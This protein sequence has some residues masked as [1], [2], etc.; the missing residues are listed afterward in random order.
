MLVGEAI[1]AILVERDIL[2]SVSVIVTKHFR[3]R[4]LRQLLRQSDLGGNSSMF[5]SSSWKELIV[6]LLSR[7]SCPTEQDSDMKQVP[8]AGNRYSLIVVADRATS[9]L[10]ALPRAVKVTEPLTKCPA[11]VFL[12]FVEPCFPESDDGG[13][14]TPKVMNLMCQWMKVELD[15]GPADHPRNL[16]RLRRYMGWLHDALALLCKQRPGR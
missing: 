2:E 6:R 12:T 9:F 14:F 10:F 3:S 13:E 4:S 7:T 5:S 16:A 8:T 11:K 1:E 15:H